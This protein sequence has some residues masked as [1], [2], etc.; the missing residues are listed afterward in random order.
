MASGDNDDDL[1]KT[2]IDNCHLIDVMIRLKNESKKDLLSAIWNAAENCVY[3]RDREKTVSLMYAIK[4]VEDEWVVKE[5]EV[6]V[7]EGEDDEL[8]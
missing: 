8:V 1:L 3:K 2:I 6:E 5:V 4:E 7:E